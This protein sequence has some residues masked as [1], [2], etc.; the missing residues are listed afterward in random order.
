MCVKVLTYRN[1][2]LVEI[3]LVIL[4]TAANS[5]SMNLIRIPPRVRFVAQHER[6]QIE[7]SMQSVAQEM[8]DECFDPTSP[9]MM[10]NDSG[11]NDDTDANSI[12]SSGFDYLPRGPPKSLTLK[13][14]NPDQLNVGSCFF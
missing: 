1:L 7:S 11:L 3:F 10:P 12:A 4:A 8:Y 13:C 9:P 14:T 6:I 5:L 2:H